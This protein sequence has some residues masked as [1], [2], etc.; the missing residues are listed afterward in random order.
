MTQREVHEGPS[1]KKVA[2]L[3]VPPNSIEAE[4]SV[5]G[6]LLLDNTAWPQVRGALAASD[7]Y[8]HEHRLI[9]AEVAQLLDAGEPA[10]IVSVFERLEQRGHDEHETGGLAYLNSLAQYIPSAAN[11]RRYAEIVRERALLRSLVSA[12]DEIATTAF[13]TQGA[14]VAKILRDATEKLRA[15]AERAPQGADAL[16]LLSLRELEK[17]SAA[18]RWLVK[19]VVPADSVGMMFGAS[20]A[21][22]SFVAIDMALHVAHGL[23][24]L[25]RK[26]SRG[27]VV[28]IAAEGG[29][30]LWRRVRAWH[31]ARHLPFG[32]VDFRVI[33]VPI[34]LNT[35]AYEVV[36]AV[37]LKAGDRA[38]ALLVVDT[39]SQTFDGEEN[40]ASEVAAYLRALGATFRAEWGCAVMVVHHSGHNATERPRGS[41]ALT[42]NLDFLFGVYRDESQLIATM[43]CEKLKDGER[44][45]PASFELSVHDLGTDEDGDKVSSLVARHISAKE[46][47]TEVM[48][49]QRLSGRG[50][51]TLQ[52]VALAEN[53]MKYQALRLAFYAE[54]GDVKSEAKQKAFV[55]AWTEAKELGY[56]ESAEGHIIV[57]K[58]VQLVDNSSEEA[59]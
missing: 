43:T 41:S 23:P 21:F 40:S 4:S 49:R 47:L 35:D 24:W 27:G 33:P 45:D 8:R 57:L 46:E 15:V 20:Q 19:H 1:D 29:A 14:P 18:V 55:R 48:E 12:A 2:Q 44:F 58:R 22:K 5:L 34:A 9:Y 56:L 38:P 30:G 7:F 17:A 28:Y 37:K 59:K 52:L 10:D 16:P 13:N 6:A 42:A 51:R 36:A 50:G 54:L 25:G 3:R 32:D 53:G 11:I 31:E 39:M 26:T